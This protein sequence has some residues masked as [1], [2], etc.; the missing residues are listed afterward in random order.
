MR[1]HWDTFRLP[2]PQESIAS[3]DIQSADFLKH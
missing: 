1:Q 2:F 3:A